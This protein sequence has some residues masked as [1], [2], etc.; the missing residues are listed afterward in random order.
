MVI[1]EHIRNSTPTPIYADGS[2]EGD[3]LNRGSGIAGILLRIEFYPPTKPL[4]FNTFIH[5]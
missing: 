2:R 4:H 5:K 1:C 3:L